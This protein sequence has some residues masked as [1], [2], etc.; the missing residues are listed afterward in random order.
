MIIVLS[1]N[2]TLDSHIIN[3][4]RNGDSLVVVTCI[5]VTCENH[6]TFSTVNVTCIA[7][8]TPINDTVIVT[9]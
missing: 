9:N 1:K 6:T 5:Y 4:A 3:F 7:D 8:D 2:I